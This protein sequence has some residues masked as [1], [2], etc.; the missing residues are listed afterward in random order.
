MKK[1]KV[2]VL[3]L[4]LLLCIGLAA[5][6]GGDS[7]QAD[8]PKIEK[9]V[10]AVAAELELSN[11]EEKAFDMIGAADGASY[12]GNIEL[13]LYEDQDS[14]AYKAVTGDGYDLGI[15]VVKATAH[16]DGMI[17]VYTGD[18]EPDKDLVDQ[19]NALAFK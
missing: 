1:R 18:G 3:V 19:F 4:S 7:D 8:V 11:K 12:D 6:G 2:F 10:D 15:T 13:Y 14:D 9:S 17:M 16:N 5:C